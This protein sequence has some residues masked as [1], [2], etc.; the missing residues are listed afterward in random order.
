VWYFHE[1][2]GSSPYRGTCSIRPNGG[3]GNGVSAH[4]FFFYCSLFWYQVHPLALARGTGS[5]FDSSRCRPSLPLFGRARRLSSA[6]LT[7]SEVDARHDSTFILSVW[8][9]GAVVSECKS[10]HRGYRS[11][12]LRTHAEEREGEILG[13]LCTTYHLST[14]RPSHNTKYLPC[15]FRRLHMRSGLCLAQ[16]C[17]CGMG[18]CPCTGVPL[19]GVP[20]VDDP[21][22]QSAHPCSTIARPVCNY[23]PTAFPRWSMFRY[24]PWWSSRVQYL[25]Q[26]SVQHGSAV[27]PFFCAVRVNMTGAGPTSQRQTDGAPVQC[28]QAYPGPEGDTLELVW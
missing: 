7:L 22:I 26:T 3:G 12:R 9:W 21:P 17:Q 23:F 14:G 8:P 25:L 10:D 2:T 18:W 13:L 27:G 20:S 6:L 19:S 5:T 11:T 1:R 15:P 24:P 16:S 4:S 28:T